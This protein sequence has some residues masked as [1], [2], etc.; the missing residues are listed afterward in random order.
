M[1]DFSN[2]QPGIGGLQTTVSYKDGG[3][4]L[5]EGKSAAR[6]RGSA[7]VVEKSMSAKWIH[8]QARC[9]SRDPK[10]QRAP[11][12][13]EKPKRYFFTRTVYSSGKS[14]S[15]ASLITAVSPSRRYSNA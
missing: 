14:L 10:A 9:A 15:V 12:T 1:A 6:A 11:E 8:V 13:G 7:A 2:A 3:A 4:A 5:G